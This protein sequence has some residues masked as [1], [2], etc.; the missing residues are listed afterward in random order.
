MFAKFIGTLQD[1]VWGTP[2]LVLLVGTGLYFTIRSGFFSVTNFSY[3]MKKTL[4]SIFKREED[5]GE[6]QV[7][8][9]QAVSTALAGTVGTGNIVGVSTAIVSG[10]PGALFWMWAAA[11]VGMMTKFAEI[12]LAIEYR[13]ID[14][15]GKVSGGPMYYITNGLNMKWLAMLFAFFGMIAPLGTG[16]ATQGQAIADTL[17]DVFGLA[18][19]ITAGILFVLISIVTLGG[20]ERIGIVAE[21]IVPAMAALYILG[22]I[23]TLFY[24]RGNLGHA[25]S[26]VFKSAFTTEAA[27]GGA[28]GVG[29]KQAIRFGIARGVFT[30]EAGFGTAPI[31]HAAAITDSSVKQGLWGIFEV[32]IDTIIIASITGLAII[33]SGALETG[34]QGGPLTTYAFSAAL[35][36]VGKY[37]VSVGLALFAF[38][39]TLGWAY[40]GEQSATFL[41]GEGSRKF[42]R[43]I[44]IFMA[45]IG[46]VAVE[47]LNLIWAVADA[48]NGLMI[49]PNL[50]GV[51][52]LSPVVLRKLKEFKEKRNRGEI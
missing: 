7:T 24:F 26:L 2:T 9:F 4:F 48:F 14:E 38:T 19:M 11:F 36:T 12:V 30:N 31:A 6:G 1:L 42:Y 3:I 8:A 41:L 32:F 27:V 33:A 43:I 23:F 28:I 45:P 29:M 46:A 47:K 13:D 40:Y 25:F 50:I 37:I 5:L 39:T 22:G 52:L 44:Y 51:L 16:G 35:P 34:L 49:I 21:R 15:D 20:I 18:P 17:Y 10:G